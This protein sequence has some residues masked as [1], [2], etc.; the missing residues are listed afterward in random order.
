MVNTDLTPLN[1]A[2]CKE[3][4]TKGKTKL[5][6]A[7]Y[8]IAS[9][10]HDLEYFKAMLSDHQAAV[11]ADQ[12]AEAA[13]AAKKASKS[14]RKSVDASAATDDA[15]EMDID[16]AATTEKPKSKKRKKEQAPGDEAEEKV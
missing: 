3:P 6:L 14:K 7:A 15:D 4:D 2:Q 8:E 9:E 12:E 11:D 5:L 13:R 1:V 16:E 10:E